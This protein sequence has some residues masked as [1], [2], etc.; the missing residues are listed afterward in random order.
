[1]TVCLKHSI[2]LVNED[3]LSKDYQIVASKLWKTF[4]N[5]S[6]STKKV[7]HYLLGEKNEHK[8]TEQGIKEYGLQKI[9]EAYGEKIV[10]EG[11]KYL[12]AETLRQIREG[13]L[14]SYINAKKLKD[15]EK[16]RKYV[17]IFVEELENGYL[18]KRLPKE[19]VNYLLRA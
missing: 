10:Q 17:N 18:R 19:K 4:K 3:K 14:E 15:K 6:I 13:K 8:I 9:Y 1:M 12:A 16:F 11:K 7:L 2:D 5:S